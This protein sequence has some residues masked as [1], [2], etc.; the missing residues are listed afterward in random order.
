MTHRPSLFHRIRRSRSNRNWNY[1][2]PT[3]QLPGTTCWTSCFIRTAAWWQLSWPIATRRRT[4]WARASA[5]S[6]FPRFVAPAS[7]TVWRICRR[8]RRACTRLSPDRRSGRWSRVQRSSSNSRRHHRR[9]GCRPCR[10]P[11]RRN[12][13]SRSCRDWRS[14]ST[15]RY[16]RIRSSSWCASPSVWCPPAARTCCTTCRRT[17]TLPATANRRPAIWWPSPPFSICAA[18][19]ASAGFQISS[20]STGEKGTLAG[21]RHVPRSL[22]VFDREIAGQGI[23]LAGERQLITLQVKLVISSDK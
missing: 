21:E 10:S 1:C 8:T 7:C 12:L 17:S 5:W 14:T 3:I 2:S 22:R 16:W 11:R 19:S 18:D 4:C 15:S 13:R 6:P 9:T 23:T 20:C